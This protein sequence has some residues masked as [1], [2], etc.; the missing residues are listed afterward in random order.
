[1][2]KKIIYKNLKKINNFCNLLCNNETQYTI[3]EWANSTF[4]NAKSALSITIR[5]NEEMAELLSELKTENYDKDKVAE[6]CVDVIIIMM[7]LFSLLGKDY[8]E[9]INKKMKINRKRQWNVNSSG[10][11]YHK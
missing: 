3:N 6:E 2:I 10:H 5:A 8:L 4:G 1:M 7:R 11:G 9:E